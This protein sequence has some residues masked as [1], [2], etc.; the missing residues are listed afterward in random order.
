[1]RNFKKNNEVCRYNPLFDS[2]ISNFALLYC[3]VHG[4]RLHTRI[5]ALAHIILVEV[6][7]RKH[8]ILLVFILVITIPL[9]AQTSD[10]TSEQTK[11]FDLSALHVDSAM[12]IASPWFMDPT[13]LWTARQGFQQI[14][15][16][17]LYSIA[18]F[19]VEAKKASIH[20]T[21]GWTLLLGGA[22]MVVG[23]SVWMVAGQPQDYSDPDYM[24]KLQSAL[25]GGMVVSLIGIIPTYI[26]ISKVR[27]NWS[28]VQQASSVAESYNEA[29][30]EKIKRY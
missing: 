3:F 8:A 21:M 12:I 16:A 14:S 29:L 11:S 19:P 9:L 1:M 13:R 4:D 27:T 18:G 20:K 24:S 23:G 22:A 15:E 2:S 28:T 26:G 30:I 25:Y 7:M 10:L 5:G 17:T 6:T